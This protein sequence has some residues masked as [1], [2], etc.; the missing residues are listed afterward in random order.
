MPTPLD[1]NHKPDISILK[2]SLSEITK[3]LQESALVIIESTVA[4]GTTREIVLKI[5][6]ESKK[7]FQ[8]AYSPERIDPANNKW[9]ISNT[10]KLVAG[11]NIE[12]TRSAKEFYETF[13]AEVTRPPVNLS[14]S[15]NA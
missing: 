6:S 14:S 10:P 11:I 7:N 5:L 4:P 2:S 9:S 3:Y 8:L 13:I 15:L 12:A 1:L